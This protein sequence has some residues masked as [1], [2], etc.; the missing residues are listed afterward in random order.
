MSEEQNSSITKA[1]EKMMVHEEAEVDS[2]LEGQATM[3]K[4]MFGFVDTMAL[5]CIVE[6]GIVDIIHSHNGPMTLS[7]IGQRLDSPCPDLTSLARVMNLLVRRKIFTAQSPSDSGETLYGLAQYSKWLLRESELSLSPMLI[8]GVHPCMLDPWKLMSNTVLDGSNPF[9]KANGHE[10]W[11]FTSTNPNFSKAF[12]DG[13]ACST[14]ITIK[15]VIT[16]YKDGFNSIGS[17]VDIG[18]GTGSAMAEV[19]KAYPHIK[20]TSFDLPHVIATAPVYPGVTHVGGDIFKTIPK[21]DAIFMKWIMHDWKDEDCVKILENCRKSISNKT[22]KVIIVDIVLKPHGDGLFDD[23]GMIFDL[24]LHMHCFGGKERTELEF[25]K[26]L[27]DAGFPRYK[28]IQ[29]PA[30]QSIIE[31]YPN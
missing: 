7:Q 26:I 17:L 24:A 29:I 11:E 16:G 9:K 2:M 23:V 1:P 20:A 22:G 12:S 3:W 21:A 25:K 19:V 5:K 6:L 27:E 30:L 15:A 10:F 8:A 28:I 31:A 14:K 18:G 13:M 4:Y